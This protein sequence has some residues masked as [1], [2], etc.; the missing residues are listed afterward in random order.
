M[1]GNQVKDVLVDDSNPTFF[2]WV[3][4]TWANYHTGEHSATLWGHRLVPA[5]KCTPWYYSRSLLV[6]TRSTL[7]FLHGT[8]GPLLM[9]RRSRNTIILQLVFPQHDH[10][11]MSPSSLV[12]VG[13]EPQSLN[14]TTKIL[15]I[16]RLC[17]I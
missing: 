11:R 1:S 8:V 4:S 7:L 3:G 2:N 12:P 13:F 17:D 5:L 9:I 10:K 6:L 15:G 14:C 16:E